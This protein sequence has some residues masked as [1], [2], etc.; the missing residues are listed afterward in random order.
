MFLPR[1]WTGAGRSSRGRRIHTTSAITS[2]LSAC[3]PPA[4]LC[5]AEDSGLVLMLQPLLSEPFLSR[6]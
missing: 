1:R 3:P 6:F 5:C 4:H 2:A